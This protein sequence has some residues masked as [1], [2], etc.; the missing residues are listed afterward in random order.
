MMFFKLNRIEDEG[1]VSGTGI[2]AEGVVFSNGR[3]VIS[4]LTDI[5]SIAIYDSIEMVEKVHGHQGK[6]RIEW[7]PNYIGKGI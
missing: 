6:T 5:S 3:C 1:G 4:W 7:Y 2:V